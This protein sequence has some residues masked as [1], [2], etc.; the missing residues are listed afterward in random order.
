MAKVQRS[1]GVRF[2]RGLGKFVVG[3]TGI[4]FGLFLADKYLNYETATRNFRAVN[5]AIATA[6]MTTHHL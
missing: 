1:F 3:S 2:I 6:V 5:A 4:G